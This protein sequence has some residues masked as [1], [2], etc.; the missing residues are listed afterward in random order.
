MMTLKET[1]GPPSSPNQA[2]LYPAITGDY[3]VGKNKLGFGLFANRKIKKG[4]MVMDEYS[5]DYSFSDVIDGD[6]LL[7]DRYKKASKKSNSD[8]P[9]YLPITRETL[10]TTHGVPCLY[11]DPSGETAGTIRWRLEVPGML[12]N[13]SCDPNTV[14]YPPDAEKGEGYAQRTIK[15]GDEVNSMRCGVLINV[16]D[17]ILGT[18]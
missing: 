5:L 2:I 3:R 7:L 4:T 8:I 11:P 14:D 16:V 13:H 15:E 9:Q 6:M 1:K 10:L 17:L 18:H 12:I